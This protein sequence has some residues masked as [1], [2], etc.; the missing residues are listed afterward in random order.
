MS[1]RDM[2]QEEQEQR[3]VPYF[4]N[5]VLFQE[6]GRGGM[7]VVYDAQ[8]ASLDRPVALKILHPDFASSQSALQRLRIEAEAAARLDH[9]NIVPIYEIGEQGGQPYL[10]MQLVEGESLAERITRSGARMAEPEAAALVGKIARAVH[11][12]HQRGILHRDLKP[13]NILLDERG[14]PHLIDFGLAKCLEQDVGITRTGAF[15]GTPAFASPEQATGN[16]R[17]LTTASDIYSLGAILYAV[18]TGQPPFTADTAAET[19]ERV[20][21]SDPPAPRS[22]RPGLAEDLE[23]IC[24]KCLQKDPARRYATALALAEDLE[25]FLEGRPIAARQVGPLERLAMWVRRKPIHAALVVV[26]G[27]MLSTLSIAAW[28]TV[29]AKAKGKE[30][31][32]LLELGSTLA[33]TLTQNPKQ[34]GWVEDISRTFA[35]TEFKTQNAYYRDQFALIL[36][37]WNTTKVPDQAETNITA[38]V[39]RPAADR[40]S[41]GASLATKTIACPNGITVDL[42]EAGSGR[43]GVCLRGERQVPFELA[44][45]HGDPLPLETVR[46]GA[47]SDQTNAIALTVSHPE[48][49]ELLAVWQAPSGHLL[50][51]WPIAGGSTV[52]VLSPDGS[53]AALG[54]RAGEAQLW[55]IRSGK[56]SPPVGLSRLPL[57]SLAL[58]PS[59]H[60][61]VGKSA[62][63]PGWLLAAGDGGGTAH[64]YD[65]SSSRIQAVCRGAHYEI[66]AL[67]FSPDGILLASG[68]RPPV[69]LWDA[70]TGA[71]VLYIPSPDSCEA[72]RFDSDG[73]QLEGRF[74]DSTAGRRRSRWQLQN[75]R[76]IAELRGLSSGVTVLAFSPQADRLAAVSHGWEIGV[77]ELRP[78]KLLYVFD[79]PQGV[80]SDNCGLAFS[81]DGRR[82]AWVAGEQAVLWDLTTGDQANSWALP[83]GITDTLAYPSKGALYLLRTET[84][85]K[86]EWPLREN[87][88]QQH[89]RVCRLR[90]LLGRE[91]EKPIYE[92]T[93]FNKH[94]LGIHASP[95]LR[96]FAVD[97]LGETDGVR[98]RKVVVLGAS[99]G[100]NVW[101]V[102]LS[103]KAPCGSFMFS[104]SGSELTF[105]PDGKRWLLLDLPEG[106]TEVHPFPAAPLALGPR[107]LWVGEADSKGVGHGLRLFQGQLACVNL[108]LDSAR[109]AFPRFDRSGRWLA[110]GNAA[111]V[112]CLCDLEE[113]RRQF[114]HAGLTW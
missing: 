104:A 44:A 106:R 77:W 86:R 27:L 7:G 26:G 80:T 108:G 109:A 98:S 12:A 20:R 14:E 71:P 64:I 62:A 31:E 23:T 74:N 92:L 28:Q 29:T 88:W 113:L 53:V 89:P 49:Q 114:A 93:A 10:A 46:L 61:R 81:P 33:L 95:D 90:N 36:G 76:G 56:T 75:G 37:G 19:I 18:V 32:R 66:S 102:N 60:R 58:A 101:E 99:T 25:R 41:P 22:I 52:L 39:P 69:N 40:N 63:A 17:Q 50:A 103:E 8:Q 96:F 43:V 13:G 51:V 91:P 3:R 21:N 9:P 79:A 87:P 11:H 1:A 84:L 57:T 70:A 73:L 97:G 4:S 45:I 47:V 67:A 110:W 94:V 82:L 78:P 16:N 55:D 24:L 2:M 38:P 15:L 105:T 59:R 72:L 35:R 112:I 6:I 65:V 54:D 85:S 42:V 107:R 34:S 83:G 5:Y 30:N 111:G 68:G 48:R 100:T